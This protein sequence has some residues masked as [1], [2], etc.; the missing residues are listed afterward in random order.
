MEPTCRLLVSRVYL[1]LHHSLGISDQRAAAYE[2]K[3]PAFPLL[4][5]LQTAASF[6]LATV[7]AIVHSETA[8]CFVLVVAMA[9]VCLPSFVQSL[10][11]QW[12]S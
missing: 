5:T 1:G 7:T 11:L 12:A 3:P 10:P 8:V 2:P 6:V 4:V 9:I